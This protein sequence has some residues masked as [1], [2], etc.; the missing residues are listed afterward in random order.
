MG[1]VLI[2]WA[3]PKNF[4]RVCIYNPTILKLLDPPCVLLS[5]CLT[6]QCLIHPGPISLP[7]TTHYIILIQIYLLFIYNIHYIISVLPTCIRT[8]HQPIVSSIVH[9][10]YYQGL[11]DR[12]RRERA[13]NYV[14]V[15]CIHQNSN[16][17]AG[18]TINS[19]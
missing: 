11:I 17:R 15:L 10:L 5:C 3:W 12:R 16:A 9:A 2:K 8:C 14:Y 19:L 18:Y 6:S 7:Y 1:V 4:A 13:C